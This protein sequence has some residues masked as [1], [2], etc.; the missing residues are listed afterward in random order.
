MICTPTIL[1]FL[2]DDCRALEVTA[3][4]GDPV[5]A[6]VVSHSPTHEVETVGDAYIAGQA[7]PP[8]TLDNYP[9]NAPRTSD[10]PYQSSESGPA[11]G[12]G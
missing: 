6:R 10:Q 5:T 9:P 8:L 1:A 11:L 4:Q 3:A 12:G 7:E 2:Q